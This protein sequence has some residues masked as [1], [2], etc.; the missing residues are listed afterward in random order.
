MLS[1]SVLILTGAGRGI[2]RAVAIE[3]AGEGATVV[4]N[5]LGTSVDG[6][7]TAADPATETAAAIEEAGGTATAHVGDVT[8]PTYTESLLADTVDAHGRIDG[9]ANFAGIVDPAPIH[10]MSVDQWERVLDVHLR[11]HFCLLKSAARQWIDTETDRQRSFLCVSSQSSLGHS[12]MAN[13]AAAKAGILG[14]MRTAANELV[15][16]GVRVNALFPSATTRISDALTDDAYRDPVPPERVAPMVAYL[17]SDAAADVT[18]CTL[19]AGGEEIGFVSDPEMSRLAY[20]EGGWT[21]ATVAEQ[22]PDSITAGIDLDRSATLVSER[23]GLD[24]DGMGST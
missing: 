16:H 17:L 23:Y 22:F 24:A 14:L 19:R 15:E 20:R 6:E 11:G 5:D 10:E 13:Y 8:D 21:T 9:V 7:G 12:A 3:L 4:V 18:G 1:D 2:G